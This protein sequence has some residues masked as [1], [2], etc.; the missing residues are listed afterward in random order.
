MQPEE[1]SKRQT[2]FYSATLVAGAFGG[3][4]AGGIIE[5]M[6]GIGNTRGWRWLF[7]IEGLATCAV[8]MAAYF[9]L[10]SEYLPCA[11]L[12]RQTTPPTPSGSLKRRR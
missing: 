5:G 2:I 11:T 9:V 7:I 4:M 10:P 12:T 6:E 1:M 8:A 3:L